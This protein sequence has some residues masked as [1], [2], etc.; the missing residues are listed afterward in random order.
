MIHMTQFR[1][2]QMDLITGSHK[3]YMTLLEKIDAVKA[4]NERLQDQAEQ[5]RFVSTRLGSRIQTYRSD[6]CRRAKREREACELAEKE[7][8]AA[9]MRQAREE[10]KQRRKDAHNHTKLLKDKLRGLQQ[11][12][13]GLRIQ[14]LWINL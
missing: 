9:R 2:T 7:V 8:K 10:E 6:L 11:Q 14:P 3:S 1:A 12:R 5:H 13:V 4:S